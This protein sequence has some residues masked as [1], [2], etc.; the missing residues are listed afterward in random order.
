MRTHCLRQRNVARKKSWIIVIGDH[1]NVW[2]PWQKILLMIYSLI[3]LISQLIFMCPISYAKEL[4]KDFIFNFAFHFVTFFTIFLI[5]FALFGILKALIILLSI[6][7]RITW[8]IGPMNWVHHYKIPRWQNTFKHV[9]LIEL[10]F[11][12]SSKQCLSTL[13]YCN[14]V[15]IHVQSPII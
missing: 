5:C 1:L 15:H 11:K 10:F 2:F 12:L 8:W 14:I 4:R 3:P 6:Q 7:C 9:S 13:L